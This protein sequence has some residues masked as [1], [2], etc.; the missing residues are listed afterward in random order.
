MK[1]VF[2]VLLFFIIPFSLLAE[3]KQDSLKVFTLKPNVITGTR[4][5]VSQA[6]IPASVSVISSVEIEQSGEKSVVKLV[7]DKIPGLFMT[8]RGVLGYGAS[9]GAAGGITIRGVGGSPTN[10]VLIM[11]DG[12]PQFMG[13]FGH[14]FPDNYLSLNTER[15]EVVRGPASVLYGT[16][17]MGGVINFI[18]KKNNTPGLKAN[19]NSSYGTYNTIVNELGLGY[20]IAGLDFYGSYNHSETDGHRDYTKFNMNSGYGKA[21]YI[22]NSTYSMTA[23][24]NISKF[25]TFD[26][27]TIYSPLINNWMEISRGSVGF[28][29]NNNYSDFDGGLK[30]YYN[31]GENNIYDGWH[32]KDK[33]INFLV[34]QNIKL[35]SDNV[36]TIGIDYKHYGGEGENLK[37]AM[38]SKNFIEGDFYVDETGVYL[39]T[40]QYFS[41]KVVANGG[42]RYENNS[43]FGSEVVPQIG[44]AYHINESN[45]VKALA[46]K[47]FRSPTIKDLFMFPVR[48]ADLKPEVVWN[49]EIGYLSRIEDNVSLEVALFIAKGDNIIV[50]QGVAPNAKL[51]NAGSFTHRGIEILSKIIASNNLNF[52][53]SYTYL[54][55]ENQTKSNPRHKFFAEANYNYENLDVNFDLK[56]ISKL[57]GDDYSRYELPD[58]TMVDGRISYSILNYAKVYVSGNNLLNKSYQT[59]YGYTMPGRNY[60]I[61]IN[62]NY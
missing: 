21:S 38:F 40:Q 59:M 19:L 23:D 17:A 58:Y 5:E 34:Y 28:A 42:I 18:T 55:P 48:N 46:S 6:N 2:I 49:Y 3:G 37:S 27:G 45:T 36:T 54:D 9:Q 12:R 15:I 35:F 33:N 43:K 53:V 52:T 50:Q 44:M 32:S 41:D 24:F 62:F 7:G 8:E 4:T 31:W 39:L 1:K 57:Y 47:G 56:Q 14:P 25:R 60:S 61:G 22:I 26:P 30:F 20:S 51:R 16:N 13:I 11:I 29:L 10:G